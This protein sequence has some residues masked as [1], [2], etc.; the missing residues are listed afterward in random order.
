[1]TRLQIGVC[2]DDVDMRVYFGA[3]LFRQTFHAAKTDF[4]LHNWPNEVAP[5]HLGLIFRIGY[6]FKL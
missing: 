3:P 2:C 6:I 1:M 5:P 4:V